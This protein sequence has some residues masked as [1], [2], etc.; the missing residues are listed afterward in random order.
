MSIYKELNDKN[1]LHQRYEIDKISMS[2]LSKEIGCNNNSVRQALIKHGFEIR[3]RSQA[4]LVNSTTDLIIDKDILDGSLMGDAFLV[5]WKKSN[6]SSP[7][8]KKKNKYSDHLEWFAKY[9]ENFPK[10]YLEQTYLKK[11]G[12][13]YVTH[14]YKTGVDAQLQEFYNRWYP[15]SNNYEKN[16]P[17]DIIPNETFLLHWFLD[18]GSSHAR[19]R[20]KEYLKKGWTQNTK[21][22]LITFSSECFEKDQQDKLCEKINNLFDLEMYTAKIVWSNSKGDHEGYRCHIPQSK[23][24]KFFEIIGQSPIKSLSYKWK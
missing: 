23:A 14:V 7:Y 1:W 12:K 24:S 2:A 19:N 15:E 20:T 9:F 13:T 8:L 18:D 16:I 22:I 11:T 6:F 21:Q 10:I 3:T 4:Q 5:K 17:D